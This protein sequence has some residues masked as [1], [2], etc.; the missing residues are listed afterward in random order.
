MSQTG[1]IPQQQAILS[2]RTQPAAKGAKRALPTIAAGSQSSR[3]QEAH[4]KVVNRVGKNS[5]KD[6]KQSMTISN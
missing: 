3:E 2:N 5:Q 6:S 4:N 1:R